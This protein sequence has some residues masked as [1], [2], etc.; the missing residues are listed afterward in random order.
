MLM[1]CGVYERDISTSKA[2]ET[3]IMEQYCISFYL[4]FYVSQ[5]IIIQYFNLWTNY[6][7]TNNIKTNEN[8]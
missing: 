2:M 3:K 7:I 4:C 8:E 5:G 6:I 1:I